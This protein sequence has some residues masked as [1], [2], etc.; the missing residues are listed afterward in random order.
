MK[1]I[2]FSCHIIMAMGLMNIISCKK[3]GGKNSPVLDLSVYFTYSNAIGS[4]LLSEAYIE[5]LAV[6][7]NVN[8]QEVRPNK[9]TGSEKGFELIPGP[10]NEKMLKVYP[11]PFLD[12]DEATVIL[13]FNNNTEDKIVYKYLHPNRNS[14]LTVSVTYNDVVVWTDTNSSNKI[15]NIIK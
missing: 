12:T 10:L 8:G 15:I 3:Q 11:F 5:N 7:Y 6:I 1:Y 14:A 4:P 9:T 2:L 13:R